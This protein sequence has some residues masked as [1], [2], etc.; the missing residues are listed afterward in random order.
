MRGTIILATK[1]MCTE[2]PGLTHNDLTIGK[3]K[4]DTMATDHCLA[5]AV[6]L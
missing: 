4:E 6:A 5:A 1:G 2:A 3:K